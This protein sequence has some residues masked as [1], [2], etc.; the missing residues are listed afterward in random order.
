[1][2]D[3]L[4]AFVAVVDRKSITKAADALSLTQSAISRRVQ[5]LEESLGAKLLDR[6]SKP[7]TATSV[8]RR[9]YQCAAP[10]LRDAERLLN[11]AREDAEP[12][13]TFRLGLTQ[14]VAD[15]ALF[16]TVVR[17]KGDFPAL[18]LRCSAEWSADLQQQLSMGNLDAAT[19]MLPAG[20]PLPGLLRGQRVGTLHVQVVQSRQRPLVEK[21]VAAS[22]L[23]DAEWILNPQ[24]CGYRA[25]LQRAIEGGG[26]QIRMGVDTHGTEM[27]LRLVAA[28]LGLGLV[29]RSV[30]RHSEHK[31]RLS[32]VDV[33]GFVLGLDVWLV[34]AA[35]LGNL[36]RA[37][38]VL[39]G[40]LTETFSRYDR[41]AAIGARRR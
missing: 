25:A 2:L 10:L 30:L 7:P 33:E 5:Q 8:G 31:A 11:V 24:G 27:Q 32:V 19:L 17:M 34:H 16:D 29:P 22:A 13:G 18:D 3:D 38:E 37:V 23:A 15:I 12:S 28:G 35:E 14:V 36:R 9:V 1:M 21:S 4:K 40:V 39:A 20:G 6:S 26:G 41:E